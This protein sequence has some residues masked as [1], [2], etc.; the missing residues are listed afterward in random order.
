MNFCRLSKAALLTVLVSI[1][2]AVS[3]AYAHHSIA[4]HYDTE[5]SITI[6]GIVT[7]FKFVNPHAFLYIDVEQ[8]DGSLANWSCEMQ[9]AVILR[10]S[11]WTQDL[12]RRG[13]R[14]V[15]NGMPARRDP[16][17]C[18]FVSA[19]LELYQPVF[20]VSYIRRVQPLFLN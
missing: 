9:A 12:I 18:G 11:G 16:Y 2:M 8:A 1:Q 7:E 5:R 20:W 19:E 13:E 17:G 15:L 4:P 6:E 10:H 14:I 3:P